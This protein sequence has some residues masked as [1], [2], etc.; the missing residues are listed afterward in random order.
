LLLEES[1]SPLLLEHRQTSSGDHT[2]G[3]FSVSIAVLVKGIPQTSLL[4]FICL[5]MSSTHPV[6]P[7]PFCN[8][9]FKKLGIHLPHCKE[10]RGKDFS[11]YLSRK[12]IQKKA[13]PASSKP[14][15]THG[16]Q[17]KRLDTH[18]WRSAQCGRQVDQSRIHLSS[19]SYCFSTGEE[20]IVESSTGLSSPS[21][22]FPRNQLMRS[23]PLVQLTIRSPF[24]YH[25][26]R[27]SGWLPINVWLLWSL[28]FYQ[29]LQLRTRTN[30]SVNAS[31]CTFWHAPSTVSGQH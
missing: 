9:L 5:E 31:T 15:P 2:F 10:R 8:Q 28:Q 22:P 30:S 11:M 12:T 16:K 24:L 21:T 29:P 1:V 13:G 25:T 17:F 26:H 27:R 19:P 23:T 6:T 18:L 3:T 20:P 7:C 14:C 4:T